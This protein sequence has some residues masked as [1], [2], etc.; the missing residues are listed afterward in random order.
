MVFA[1]AR[2]AAVRGPVPINAVI[3]A[4]FSVNYVRVDELE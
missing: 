3:H 1:A 4:E 2:A